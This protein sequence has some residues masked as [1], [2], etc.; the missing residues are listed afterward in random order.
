MQC[1][2]LTVPSD[3]SLAKAKQELIDSREEMSAWKCQYDSLHRKYKIQEASTSCF[4]VSHHSILSLEGTCANGM[5]KRLGASRRKHCW[6]MPS[7][8]SCSDSP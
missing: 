2:Y 1:R 7:T 6:R 5:L 4:Q 3:E 8:V